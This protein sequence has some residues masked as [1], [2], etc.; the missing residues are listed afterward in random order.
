M[1]TLNRRLSLASD[2]SD[3][4]QIVVA[5]TGGSGVL[6]SQVAKIIHDHWDDVV[7]IRLFDVNPPEQHLIT[8]ITGYATPQNKPK[9]TYIPGS[10]LNNDALLSAFV[11]VNVVIHCAAIVER[12][13]IVSRRKMKRV[14]VDGTQNV[15]QACL[16][17]GV[18][19]LV[20]TASIVQAL[21]V[22]RNTKPLRLDESMP[23]PQS[24]GD[25]IF[26]HYGGS[27]NE[28]ENL[29]LVA[30]G[31]E[32]KEH[33]KLHTCSLRCPPMF[34]EG[35]TNFVFSALKM[36]QRCYGYLVPVGLNIG[37]GTT[38]QSLYV[39][40]AAWAHVVAGQKL[41]LGKDQGK[42]SVGGNFY[43]V[44]DHTPI[45]TMSKFQAQFLHPMGFK[46]LPIGVPLFFLMLIAYWIEFCLL[47][48][49]IV[50]VDVKCLLTRGSVRYF[51]VSHSFSWEKARKELGYEPLYSHKVAL[52][53]SMEYYRGVM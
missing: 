1:S 48:L 13:S 11:H 35:D 32:G 53:K 18:Q 22:P 27:K 6:G 50:R 39:G 5:I 10:V 34:G 51:K 38:M 31:Q 46:V 43:Y 19:A 7:E 25:L 16:E 14:N 15:I 28:S 52:A 23:L 26:P 44:G 33:V 21:S 8:T 29:I 24:Y 9:V 12:G 41:L 36:A 42:T 2:F 20:Y 4:E 3:S 49:S 30:N 17:C 37:C 47:L 45:S 40:N